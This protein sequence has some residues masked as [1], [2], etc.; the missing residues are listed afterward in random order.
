MSSQMHMNVSSQPG[1]QVLRFFVGDLSNRSMG[2]ASSYSQGLSY[3]SP[4]FHQVGNAVNSFS[5]NVPSTGAVSVTIAGANFAVNNPT[6]RMRAGFTGCTITEWESDSQISALPSSG[7]SEARTLAIT[8]SIRIISGTRA[9]SYD[10]P[11]VSGSRSSNSPKT[12][13]QQHTIYGDG[14]GVANSPLVRLGATAAENTYWKSHTSALCNSATS[15]GA[16]R[17]IFVTAGWNFGSSTETITFDAHSLRSYRSPLD[18]ASF[19]SNL[20]SSASTSILLTGK[21]F[22]TALMSSGVRSGGSASENTRWFSDTCL[23]GKMVGGNFHS[24]VAMITASNAHAGIQGSQTFAISYDNPIMIDCTPPNREVASAQSLTIQGAGFRQV[25]YSINSRIGGSTSEATTWI[26]NTVMHLRSMVVTIG[27]NHLAVT[28]GKVTSS[29]TN[30]FYF[31]G[32]FLSGIGI[33][34]GASTGS[35][36]VVLFG[37]GFSLL[38]QTAS[39]SIGHSSCETSIWE[40]DSSMLVNQVA[41]GF[42]TLPAAITIGRL[43]GIVTEVFSF[44]LPVVSSHTYNTRAVM[45]SHMLTVTGD[46]FAHSVAIQI[47]FTQCEITQWSSQTSVNCLR[48]QGIG[49]SQQISIT[50]GILTGTQSE[51]ISYLAPFASKARYANAGTHGTNL[52]TVWGAGVGLVVTTMSVSPGF[53]AAEAT[54]WLANTAMICRFQL[55]GGVAASLRI[56]VTLGH[57]CAGSSSE[58]YS[59]DR[60]QGSNVLNLQTTGKISMTILGASF[61]LFSATSKSR[62]GASTDAEATE[63][64]A[65]TAIVCKS[66]A[67]FGVTWSTVITTGVRS[68]SLSEGISYEVVLV[69]NLRPQNVPTT[70]AISISITG[71][72]YGNSQSTLKVR[73]IHSS[74]E[75]SNWDS[76]STVVCSLASGFKS[77]GTATLTS[78]ILAGSHT[79]FFSYNTISISAQSSVNQGILGSLFIIIGGSWFGAT[80]HSI[81]AGVGP[82]SCQIASWV[83]EA[84]AL[85]SWNYTAIFCRVAH[86]SMASRMLVL[87]AGLGV[88]T[89]TESVSIE[90]PVISVLSPQNLPNYRTS[91]LTLKGWDF[92]GEIKLYSVQ[93]RLSQTASAESIW[94][95]SSNIRCQVF[96]GSK[97]S[98]QVIV[99]AGL[100]VGSLSESLSFE[101]SSISQ[102]MSSNIPIAYGVLVTVLGNSLGHRHSTASVR[103]GPST[104][105]STEWGGNFSWIVCK[106][107]HVGHGATMR[108][109]VTAGGR[110]G[111]LSNSLSFDRPTISSLKLPNVPAMLSSPLILSGSGFES[112]E[113]SFSAKASYT[114]CESTVWNS[115]SALNCQSAQGSHASVKV[116]ITAGMQL[117]TTSRAL[118]HDGPAVATLGNFSNI[119]AVANIRVALLGT[120][121]GSVHSTIKA[122][123]GG[124]ACESTEWGGNY[125]WVVCKVAQTGHSN[126]MRAALTVHSSDCIPGTVTDIMSYD[127]RATYMIQS[128]RQH[129][130][131]VYANVPAM[132]Q[133]TTITLIGSGFEGSGLNSTEMTHRSQTGA[134]SCEA[135]EW[136]NSSKIQCKIAYGDGRTSLVVVTAGAKL[137]SVSQLLSFDGP[138]PAWLGIPSI[139]GLG[140]A[141]FPAVGNVTVTVQGTGYWVLPLRYL[142]DRH[143]TIQ[144]QS[145][146]TQCESTAWGNGSVSVFCKIANIGHGATMRTIVTAGM[147]IGTLSES[148]S[149]DDPRISSLKLP[150]VP[151]MLSSPLILSGSGFESIEV[152]FSAKASYTACESTVW[153]STSALNCQSAQGSHASVKVHITA[154]MQLG[155]T[156]QALSHDGASISM[157]NFGNVAAISGI[158]L[159]MLGTSLGSVH[160][161]VNARVGDSACESTEWGGNYTWVVCKVARIGHQDTMR[162]ALTV[163]VGRGILGTVTETLSYNAPEISSFWVTNIPVQHA[164]ATLTLSGFGFET[165]A[166]NTLSIRPGDTDCE[167]S[168]WQSFSSILCRVAYASS[169]GTVS[170]VMTSGARVGTLS[171]VL[172]YDQG[173]ISNLHTA[174]IPPSGNVSLTVLGSGI[175]VGGIQATLQARWDVTACEST[176]WLSDS[177]ILCKVSHVGRGGSAAVAVTAGMLLLDTRSASISYDLSVLR[178]LAVSNGTNVVMISNQ[179]RVGA[180]FL[181]STSA[182]L[183]A[184]SPAMHFG[185]TF[186]EATTWVSQSSLICKIAAG[187]QGSL[188]LVLTLG[189]RVAT[190]SE[191][192]CYDAPSITGFVLSNISIPITVAH[193][194]G[195]LA[196]IVTSHSV[197]ISDSAGEASSWISFTSVTCNIGRG[198]GFTHGTTITSGRTS[199]TLTSIFSYA[200]ASASGMSMN[201]PVTGSI[202]LTVMGSA[203]SRWAVSSTLRMGH[204]AAEE[205]IWTSESGVYCRIAAG[206]RT[207][208]RTAVSVYA[209][210]IGTVSNTLTYDR[211]ILDT[212]FPLN[213]PILGY[214]EITLSGSGFG[215]A[216]YSPRIRVGDSNCY[217]VNFLSQSSLVCTT[218]RGTG[219]L[220]AISATVTDQVTDVASRCSM[221]VNG[222]RSGLP[223]FIDDDCNANGYGACLAAGKSCVSHLPQPP[224]YLMCADNSSILCTSASFDDCASRKCSTCNS[225]YCWPIFAFCY[226]SPKTDSLVPNHG[227][228]TGGFSLTI[229]GANFD[230]KNHSADAQ[231]G[232]TSS[233]HT[234]Y[235]SDTTVMGM[236][237]P[238]AGGDLEV[239]LTILGYDQP[240]V[241]R[242]SYLAPIVLSVV[243]TNS[244][245]TGLEQVVIFGQE[246]SILDY[247]LR[248][249]LGHTGCESTVW[250]SY[251]SVVARCSNHKGFAVSQQVVV[252]VAAQQ[253][254]LSS[255]ITFD[256]HLISSIAR[257]NSPGTGIVAVDVT[258]HAF[259]L[260]SSTPDSNI[261]GTASEQTLWTSETAVT[262]RFHHGIDQ[263]YSMVITVNQRLATASAVLSYDLLQLST[264]QGNA[265]ILASLILTTFGSNLGKASYSLAARISKGSEQ[266]QGCEVTEWLSDSSLGLTP[267]WGDVAQSLGGRSIVATVER[268]TG[269][270]SSAYSYNTGVV[271]GILRT[272][273]PAN[274]SWV[275][276]PSTGRSSIQIFGLNWGISDYTLHAR[277]GLTMCEATSWL[278]NTVVECRTP[279]GIRIDK[280]VAITVHANFDVS[281]QTAV[282][283]YDVHSIYKT[284]RTNG[285][286]AGSVILDVSLKGKDFTTSNPSAASR[287][288]HT[289]CLETQWVSD[290]ALLTKT[291]SGIHAFRGSVVTFGFMK[292]SATDLFSYNH[293]VVSSVGMGSGCTTCKIVSMYGRDLATC[294]A[295]AQAR[296]GGL[297]CEATKWMSDTMLDCRFASDPGGL[298]KSN[299]AVITIMERP[300]S[301][302]KMI[303]YNAPYVSSLGV[304]NAA[305]AGA[306]SLTIFGSR[307][308][309]GLSMLT[310]LELG[311]SDFSPVARVGFTAGE[312]SMWI[313]DT[314]LL[315][316]QPSGVASLLTLVASLGVQRFI[317]HPYFTF[318]SAAVS[319]VSTHNAAYLAGAHVTVSG[320]SFGLADY[321]QRVIFGTATEV[322]IWTS[323]TSL[324]GVPAPGSVDGVSVHV[325]VGAHALDGLGFSQCLIC[326]QYNALTHVWSYDSVSVGDV[327]PPNGGSSGG[328]AVTILGQHFAGS[329][330]S[331]ETR[332]GGTGCEF[333]IWLSSTAVLCS[334]PPGES[335]Q[336]SVTVTTYE[337]YSTHSKS[338]TFDELSLSAVHP[339]NGPTTGDISVLVIGQNLKVTDSSPLAFIQGTAC[340]ASAWISDSVITCRLSAGSCVDHD[341]I[342]IVGGANYTMFSSFSYD[343]PTVSSLSTSSNG[344][345]NVV[346]ISVMGNNFASSAASSGV[347]IGG[348]TAM[349]TLWTSDSSIFAGAPSGAQ[350]SHSIHVTVCSNGNYSD[351][352]G[353]LS[354]AFSFDAPVVIGA[355]VFNETSAAE[356]S[357]SN[358]PS[359]STPLFMMTGRSF[360]WVSYSPASRISGT[361]SEQT[362]WYSD[363]SILASSPSP[364][365][366]NIADGT[367]AVTVGNVGLRTQVYSYNAP[368]LS[369]VSQFTNCTS[370]SSITLLGSS[371]KGV[372]STVQARLGGLPCQATFWISDSTIAC[373]IPGNSLGLSVGSDTGA[374]VTVQGQ[375]GSVTKSLAYTQPNL[376]SILTSNMPTTGKSSATISGSRFGSGLSFLYGIE[377]G[378]V[379]S[380][381]SFR[382]GLTACEATNWLSDSSVLSK[383]SAGNTQQKDIVIS[384]GSTR[385]S[386]LIAVTYDAAAVSSVGQIT[387]CTSC[388]SLTLFGAS[389]AQVDTS[390]QVRLG[391]IPCQASQWASDSSVAC[392][393]AANSLG[394]SAPSDSGVV[395]TVALRAGSITKT[396]QYA[397]PNI[398]SVHNTNSYDGG[399]SSITISG[400]RFGSGLSF[401]LGVEVGIADWSLAS[402]AGGTACESTDWVSDSALTIKLSNGFGSDRAVILTLVT[403]RATS[404][405]ALT[406]DAPVIHSGKAIA[407]GTTALNALPAGAIS[408]VFLGDS[409]GSIQTSV[410]SRQ[411]QTAAHQTEWLSSTSV[412][413]NTPAGFKGSLQI[414]VTAGRALGTMTD[415]ISFDDVVI[416][417][418]E[419]VNAPVGTSRMIS[420]TANHLW[421][422]DISSQVRLHSTATESSQWFSDTC[423]FG[424][425]SAGVATSRQVLITTGSSPGS[426]TEV[427][428]YDRAIVNDWSHGSN[429][430]VQSGQIMSVQGN[431]F[432]K[433][434][435]T[436]GLRLG[437]T[438]CEL[439]LW[440][441]DSSLLCKPSSGLIASLRTLVTVGVQGATQSE[442]LSYNAPTIVFTLP[443]LQ[444]STRNLSPAPQDLV[445]VTGINF[446]VYAA[447]SSLRTGS[448]ASPFTQWTSFTAIIARAAPGYG[449]T[450]GVLTAGRKSGSVSSIFTFDS[451]LSS[452]LTQANIMTSGSGSV[453]L[454][455]INFLHNEQTSAA[456]MGGTACQ[457]TT[458]ASSSSLI[459]KVSPGVS[460]LLQ[461]TLTMHSQ[462]RAS[463]T[464]SLA[465]SYS[466]PTA[467]T[468]T[469]VNAPSAGGGMVTL[470]G[471]SFGAFDYSQRL[472]LGGTACSASQW[473]IEGAVFCKTPGGSGKLRDLVITVGQQVGTLSG[474]FT[475]NLPSVNTIFPANS[476]TTGG[477]TLTMV[478]G[479]F[480]NAATGQEIRVGGTSCLATVYFSD[481]SLHCKIPAGVGKNPTLEV[482]S[483]GLSGIGRNLLSYDSPSISAI[484][485]SNDA[486]SGGKIISIFG[487]GFG[488]SDFTLSNFTVHAS[489]NGS[490]ANMSGYHSDST[491]MILAPAGVGKSL[492]PFLT[493]AEQVGLMTAAF[494]YDLPVLTH[495]YPRNSPTKGEIIV[496]VQGMNL[497]DGCYQLQTARILSG[498]ASGTIVD[499]YEGIV[500]GTPSFT[501]LVMVLGVGAGVNK[502]LEI[503]VAEQSGTS[504]QPMVFN[505]DAPN[506]TLV[507]PNFG[508]TLG[509]DTLS[510]IGN[511]F[512]PG[513]PPSGGPVI[514]SYH[515]ANGFPG[516]CA[517]ISAGVDPHNILYCV[518]KRGAGQGFNLTVN[519]DTQI[520]TS[521][522]A[523]SYAAPIVVALTP[524]FSP[525]AGGGTLTIFGSNFGITDYQTSGQVGITLCQT[526]Q[527]S[528]DSQ[529]ECIVPA[530]AG[531]GHSIS[532][533][534]DAQYGSR[535]NLFSY[536]APRLVSSNPT[537]GQTSGR[538][539]ATITGVN[540]G[541]EDIYNI[542]ASVGGRQCSHATF[543]SD[544]SVVCGTPVGGG[545]QVLEVQVAGQ[546]SDLVVPFYYDPPVV[547]SIT[548][549][550]GAVLGGNLLQVYGSNFGP[551]DTAPYVSIGLVTGPLCT[552][553]IWTSDTAMS[554]VTPAGKGFPHDVFVA[555]PGFQISKGSLVGGF[556][557]DV[558]TLTA[559]SPGNAPT[560]GSNIITIRGKNL[561]SPATVSIGSTISSSVTLISDTSIILVAPAGVGVGHAI[562][563]TFD[564]DPSFGNLQFTY[565]PPVITHVDPGNGPTI[566]GNFVTI[567]GKNFGTS[568]EIGL[569]LASIGNT[570]CSSVVAATD[571][572]AVECESSGGYGIALP[573]RVTVSSQVSNGDKL[574]SYDIPV[575]TAMSPN[576]AETNTSTAVIILGR[577]FGEASAGRSAKI[578]D[579]LCSTL[580]FISFSSLGCT[581]EP[582]L[583]ALLDV[584]VQVDI[585]SGSTAAIF[586]YY[587]P[588]VNTLYRANGP[589]SGG[590]TTTVSGSHFG[591][592]D[593]TILGKVEAYSCSPISWT[594]DS[595]LL[596][597][598]PANI[599]KNRRFSLNV[600]QQV[601]TLLAGYSYNAPILTAITPARTP[602]TGA[603]SGPITLHGFNFGTSDPVSQA[604]ARVGNTDC[605]PVTWLSDNAI[606]ATVPNGEGKGIQTSVAIAG[607]SSNLVAA[608]SYDPPSITAL[609]YSTSNTDGGNTITILGY[610]FGTSSAVQSGTVGSTSAQT[611]YTS[612]IVSLLTIPPGTGKNLPVTVN[613]AGQLGTYAVCGKPT[614]A[615]S[616]SAPTITHVTPKYGAAAGSSSITIYGLN[617]GQGLASETAASVHSLPCT[618]TVF[619]SS[620]RIICTTSPNSLFSN[621]TASCT[622]CNAHS[623]KS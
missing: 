488:T 469:I 249:R 56:R 191:L 274:A 255:T 252:T 493:V 484:S 31:N 588:I 185:S 262:A 332:L 6:L 315:V 17:Q 167:W 511:N 194:S 480:G 74:A 419:V 68:G 247:S 35:T 425:H 532:V 557:Y 59:Y 609:I 454:L 497:G 598:V 325:S 615:F 391:G 364:A 1:L 51:S 538:T 179:A 27:N 265:P 574:F 124:S 589:P 536:S 176:S 549:R 260:F 34:N 338:F 342:A 104:C 209:A 416:S 60:I 402:R 580:S 496:T 3:D 244:L 361:S 344:A 439:S 492:S 15:F 601:V 217:S 569:V 552:S 571:H 357:V 22:A 378:T 616:Y 400:E 554:T 283:T 237:A 437:Y 366:S 367:F 153:N 29:L 307:F 387:G 299:G 205:S 204:T 288:G 63:W 375:A 550:N 323:D 232:D 621:G 415:S 482:L 501:E 581:V 276:G 383:M 201:V 253:G 393:I 524:L 266:D 200:G 494:S 33:G 45:S 447:S 428:T 334:S 620:T 343:S 161:T 134:T 230:L 445:S 584:L 75:A 324:S 359:T 169:Q 355:T 534:S 575:I 154:G 149:F 2:F 138:T 292:S 311:S 354:N 235:V 418:L 116:H 213:G 551:V 328:F 528:A 133:S 70:S 562:S 222:T 76:D 368:H 424:L 43:R 548:P 271:S 280:D 582:G 396:L 286:K 563:G 119:P 358:L 592:Y 117:G 36:L 158:K 395:I 125:A 52:I 619:V 411:G 102:R 64:L 452:L 290:S 466:A 195:A 515:D 267:P 101:A 590:T 399:Q 597:G 38:P 62:V 560:S 522:A 85:N 333:S 284:E 41:G 483:S 282:F 558:P 206:V 347:R 108:T 92:R 121:L 607:Q 250:I 32:K 390:S 529:I 197:R 370:C 617:F 382:V 513:L 165:R 145:G 268:R 132:L 151:A 122:R 618:S 233:M 603:T 503:T 309:S 412:N 305:T 214:M 224:E 487:S 298:W 321:S 277:M 504:I 105:Q 485:P 521:Q 472:R 163:F 281:S 570:A 207:Q 279:T 475:F 531:R 388:N 306:F 157:S 20:D 13:L 30:A 21:N 261:G 611:A 187:K 251:S 530:G 112:S 540:F 417:G 148:M 509:G 471:R 136:T 202:S 362:Q 114:A 184:L 254:T 129:L 599:G 118:S 39:S 178:M 389:F 106:V 152:S 461:T 61:S 591:I 312:N 514:I 587:A 65:D 236:V 146:S 409:L 141:N 456:R 150:N 80:Q 48:A 223:C 12:G 111:S 489:I 553:N 568:S 331:P 444:E 543:V 23:Q 83:A 523:F 565:D 182:V 131:P 144:V 320:L 77:S 243:Q 451:P 259:G 336:R 544:S 295:S 422:L 113:V 190:I 218:P 377:V 171:Q 410:T 322:T 143:D 96:A 446:G 140:S 397:L 91:T 350:I 71:A 414:I 351:S 433:T 512:G 353:I 256:S 401:V 470:R 476:P 78:G 164:H 273:S 547:T 100:R 516:E 231:F 8:S 360:S 408:I 604:T 135:T 317:T 159:T 226:D 506:I 241:N 371:F 98:T 455:G 221:C 147:I 263:S 573:V 404:R 462:K 385:H 440:I 46:G 421:L 427:L 278:S 115:T 576:V 520:A 561:V 352:V 384:V 335:N 90:L 465:F 50:T 594:S 473:Q 258:G 369:S 348:T 376:T 341:V 272:D 89:M 220:H 216:D 219:A 47:Q 37:R 79:R 294:S 533:G 505:F 103:S 155:T 227:S 93:T 525:T 545:T 173:T 381:V 392:R 498:H 128:T 398:T 9:L 82:T 275:N 42:F 99:T 188:S 555:I 479:E 110:V 67:G 346:V 177:R 539:N 196:P 212:I 442:S 291:P 95:S 459:C 28:A 578:G 413:T 600:A 53:S 330:H 613:I 123:T 340:Q 326:Y 526:A 593:S 10:A 264:S 242:F 450:F 586:S 508:G 363:S 436:H 97:S 449:S 453:T 583:G 474:L 518:T 499:N 199:G 556:S 225:S 507:F 127:Q 426:I 468:S 458:W 577:N 403:L 420:V 448:T 308:G 564:G 546:Q 430:A 208:L 168:S 313:S 432:V 463:G 365:Y 58:I 66:A 457:A 407:V 25:G 57:S 380:T 478:G 614:C 94:I 229:V 245:S 623:G 379:D 464:L 160:V 162:L 605:P 434:D 566:G 55:P 329:D 142:G 139:A 345:S 54:S 490:A 406:F 49:T 612:H 11:V 429:I 248:S 166:F 120:S 181:S 314:S 339:R 211:P 210:S 316:K 109:I 500:V 228:T 542:S 297:S 44:Q 572:V 443:S 172:T 69:S 477:T 289:S 238:G 318:D 585:I 373:R 198:L 535:A 287:T 183:T 192:M 519:I 84:A 300:G 610:N 394:L 608:F 26:S 107:A 293:P 481:S 189:Q 72:F 16:S 156:S 234:Y 356:L 88:G 73:L 622:Q 239:R 374:V 491:I 257:A 349:N 137:S 435:F 602:T 285:A 301:L 240:F 14:Y 460:F 215:T 537:G 269:T 319:E 86:G 438:H 170:V 431:G 193:I 40:S 517:N 559:I 24:R 327:F 18:P 386:V 423:I 441:S 372:D 467:S 203:F 81:K 541:T 19:A 7:H 270:L 126:T 567:R 495:I 296:L 595:S 304:T 87:T 310:G 180:E 510:V 337:R 502:S 527:W 405:D 579:T 302:T 303:T 5:K 175:V 186:T 174:N 130:G 596:C 4:S 246:F 606:R 486:T